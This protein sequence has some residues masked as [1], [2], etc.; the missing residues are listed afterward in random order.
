MDIGTITT[1]A[2]LALSVAT[3]Y[4]GRQ[5]SSKSEGKEFGSLTKEL[6]YI[7]EGVDRIEGRLNDD[8]RRLENRIDGLYKQMIEVSDTAGRGLE[9]AKSE[10]NRLNEHLEREHGITV[11][12]SKP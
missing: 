9:S 6:Q 12:K 10:H 2:A 4:I 5:S 11:V 1:I 7:K 3:F 8:I